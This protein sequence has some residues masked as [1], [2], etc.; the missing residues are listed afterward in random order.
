MSSCLGFTLSDPC[1]L[2][3]SL[4]LVLE[5]VGASEIEVDD[6]ASR[7]QGV[8]GAKAVVSETKPAQAQAARIALPPVTSSGF[9]A[10]R[11]RG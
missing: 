9:V 7:S 11:I 2:I 1:P 10:R 5:Q 6:H 4:V 3:S 8:A